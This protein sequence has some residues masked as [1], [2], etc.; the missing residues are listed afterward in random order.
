M[1]LNN[2]LNDRTI[3]SFGLSIGTGLALESVFDPTQERYDNNRTIPNKININDYVYHYINIYTLIRNILN[4]CSLLNVKELH[5]NYTN[6]TLLNIL[7]A[8]TN[9]IHALYTNNTDCKVIF[10][11]PKYKWLL[12][13]LEKTKKLDKNNNY[14]ENVKIIYLYNYITYHVDTL[15]F[16]CNL[17][18]LEN[19]NLNF[20]QNQKS[21]ITTHLGIDLC[22]KN[23]DL[24]ESHTGLL[25]KSN[26]FNSKYIKL[27]KDYDMSILPYNDVLLSIFGD[28]SLI[29][30]TEREI[31]LKTYE[32]AK[33][34][35]S[36]TT[37]RSIIKNDLKR[38]GI[39]YTE[40]K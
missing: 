19:Y 14:I 25:K 18:V 12:H 8:E 34:R 35:W 38:Y 15:S 21:L 1:A 7:V 29:P 6:T 20:V 33:K 9:L 3:T 13:T 36:F 4:A 26:S 37:G 39:P 27:G 31:R 17:M 10:Y 24:L 32:L 2:Q 5:I 30:P 22:Y 11:L 16:V 28:K 40:L 23:I